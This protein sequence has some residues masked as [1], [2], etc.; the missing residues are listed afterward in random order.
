M[1]NNIKSLKKNRL[2]FSLRIMFGIVFV[3][4]SWNKILDPEGF[5]R[6]VQNY[7]ILPLV[8]VKPVALILPWIEAVGGIFLITGYLI[9]GSAFIFDMLL[10]IFI[11]AF[12]VNLFR[13]IDVSC[14]CFSLTLKETKGLYRYLIRDLMLLGVGLWVFFYRPGKED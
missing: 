12:I 7:R 4:A 3:W 1:F 10:I 11:A 14:G 8:L 5:V 2:Y 9:K 13:G 6:I